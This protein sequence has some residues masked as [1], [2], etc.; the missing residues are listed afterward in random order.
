MIMSE[1][2]MTE[3]MAKEILKDRKGEEKR[4]DAQEYLCKYV[5]ENCGLL[6]PCAMVK[7]SL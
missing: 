7:I 5:D 6:H 1:Y 4:M 3:A 2:N